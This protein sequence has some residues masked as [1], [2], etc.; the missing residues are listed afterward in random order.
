[1]FRTCAYAG[2]EAAYGVVV[3]RGAS[4]ATSAEAQKVLRHARLFTRESVKRRVL[5]VQT[6]AR[7]GTFPF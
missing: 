5:G 4:T 1:M 2:I 6:V 3:A 7:L